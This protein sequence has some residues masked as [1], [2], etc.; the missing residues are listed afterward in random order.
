MKLPVVLAA[1]QLRHFEKPKTN[2]MNSTGATSFFDATIRRTGASPFQ[3][4]RN[5]LKGLFER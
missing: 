5:L 1:R 3:T 4:T 2:S